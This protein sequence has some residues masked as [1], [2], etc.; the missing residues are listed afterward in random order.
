MK[1]KLFSLTLVLVMCLG[2]TT[3]ASAYNVS[4][5]KQ[6]IIS[7]G[8][9]HTGVIDTNG[10]LWMWG[11]NYDGQL[12]NGG[13]GNR[14]NGIGKY[15]TVPVKL[16]NNVVSVSSGDNHTAAIKTDGS[17]W[18]W[19]GNYNG[20]LGNG[21]KKDSLVPIMVLKNVVSVSSGYNYT[22]AIKTD[23]SLWMWGSN[24]YGKLGKGASGDSTV[25]VKVLEN[26]VSVS[27][28]Y[29]HTAAIKSDGSLWMWGSNGYGKLGNGG[30]GNHE[31]SDGIELVPIQNVPTKVMD[32]VATVN[33]TL[34]NT[35]A[36]TKDGSLWMWGSNF[37]GQLG[38]GDFGKF[39]N[40]KTLPIKVMDD[41]A[42]VSGGS[43][44]T[45][46][47]KTDGS[48]W[49]WGSNATGELGN[50]YDGNKKLN[51][52]HGAYPVQ[53]V[54]AKVMNGVV[55]ISCGQLYSIIVKTDGT[56]WVCGRN[57]TG[58]LGN[59]GQNN[60]IDIYGSAMQ[61]TPMK[62]SSVKAKLK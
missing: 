30:K 55:T 8:G 10:S 9:L 37:S 40:Y 17:L 11:G 25:P 58:E 15:Q 36:I 7:A 27:S 57:S 26:V 1:K 50:G 3:S 32:D 13:G 4:Q 35:A 53:T 51:D 23:G 62:L 6:N 49:M 42:Y 44:F 18:M 61:T 34:A 52:G 39:V 47:I 43:E 21:T 33:C 60:R 38:N 28:G 29:H 16:L 22:A 31:I 45:A 2:V 12:G 48:L 20:Q 24:E 59:A 14:Q 41:V 5:K 19:G 46:A 54:P 56:I